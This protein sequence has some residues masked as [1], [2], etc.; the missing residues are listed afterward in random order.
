MREISRVAEST[1]KHLHNAMNMLYNMVKKKIVPEQ[2]GCVV[3][4][5]IGK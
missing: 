4:I 1:I 5:G 3:S 2:A